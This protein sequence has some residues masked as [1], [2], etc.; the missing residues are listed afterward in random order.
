MGFF[1]GQVYRHMLDCKPFFRKL[2]MLFASVV[3]NRSFLVFFEY[4]RDFNI[5]SMSVFTMYGFQHEHFAGGSCFS[6]KE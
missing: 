4:G 2:L 5:P 6:M 1:A 3:S